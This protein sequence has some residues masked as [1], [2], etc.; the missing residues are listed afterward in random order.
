MLIFDPYRLAD[1]IE[2]FKDIWGFTA[3]CKNGV[4]DLY[5][6]KSAVAVNAILNFVTGEER[7]VVKTRLLET[8]YQF[9]SYVIQHDTVAVL[10]LDDCV[11]KFPTV[12]GLITAFPDKFAVVSSYKGDIFLNDGVTSLTGYGLPDF[13]SIRR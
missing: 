13:I 6:T 3:P 11:A 1:N 9:G 5:S 2:D 10:D 4:Y 8:L 12:E 7:Y